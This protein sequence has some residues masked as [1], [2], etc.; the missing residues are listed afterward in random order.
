MEKTNCDSGA[1]TFYPCGNY[2][3]DDDKAFHPRVRTAT[4]GDTVFLVE[5]ATSSTAKE[6]V[7]NKV[8]RLIL[9][10]CDALRQRAVS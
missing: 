2:D 5:Y 3:G 6:T 7:Y 4:H 1:D 8:K 9:S 10:D